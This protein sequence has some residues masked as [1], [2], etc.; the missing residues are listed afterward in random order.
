MD[1]VLRHREHTLDGAILKVKAIEIG[2][3]LPAAETDKSR[4]IEVT[5]LATATTKDAIINFFEN[6]KR[7]G[8]GD[9]ESINHIPDQG[10]AVITFTTAESEYRN[11][12]PIISCLARVFSQ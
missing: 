6:N 8:G 11:I 9:V 3:N 10:T 7:S 4:T 2:S 5:G 1:G 12:H